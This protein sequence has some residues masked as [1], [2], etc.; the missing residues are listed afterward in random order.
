MSNKD[1]KCFRNI[2]NIKKDQSREM[3][4]KFKT[5]RGREKIV[6]LFGELFLKYKKDEDEDVKMAIK[7]LKA[8]TSPRPDIIHI[9]FIK[10]TANNLITPL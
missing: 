3:K 4:Y 6:N 5:T 7:K 9:I 1:P 8:H 2:R 10:R